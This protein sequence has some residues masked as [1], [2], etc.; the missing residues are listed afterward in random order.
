MKRLHHSLQL[1]KSYY[2]LTLLALSGLSGLFTFV[3]NYLAPG[4]IC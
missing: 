4:T 2:L 3:K 1:K